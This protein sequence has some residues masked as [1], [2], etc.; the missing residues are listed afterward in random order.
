MSTMALS[1]WGQPHDSLAAIAPDATHIDYAQH[2]LAE[3]LGLIAHEGSTHDTVIGWSLGGQ[4]AVRAIAA[5]MLRPKRLV[6]ITV[7]FQFVQTP[8]RAIGM[9]RDLYDKFRGNYARN[10]AR[11]LDK[12]WELIAKGDEKEET[13]RAYMAKGSKED[14]QTRKWLYWLDA[15]DGFSCEELNFSD[16]PPTLLINGTGDAV[17]EHAQ[18]S[19]FASR[20]LGAKSITVQGA[21]HAPHWHDSAQLQEWIKD[22]V[23]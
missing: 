9:K 22:H 3:A 14:T 8:E 5:G 17:V 13:V 11:T 19:Q 16:F 4:L 20:I 23:R 18:Q 15:L 6:L 1:G 12:A 2:E 21:G 10:S 7:P